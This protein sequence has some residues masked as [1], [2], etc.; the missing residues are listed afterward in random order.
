M[1][2][3]PLLIMTFQTLFIVFS[4]EVCIFAGWSHHYC[5][6]MLLMCAGG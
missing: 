3:L 4:S 2:I 6:A 1:L 5:A